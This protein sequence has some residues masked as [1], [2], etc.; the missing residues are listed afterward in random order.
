MDIC[1][2]LTS[3]YFCNLVFLMLVLLCMLSR[4]RKVPF[5]S[6][7]DKDVTYNGINNSVPSSSNPHLFILLPLPE[8]HLTFYLVSSLV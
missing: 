6:N 5:S 1:N 8:M 4:V 2:G 7:S 3:V